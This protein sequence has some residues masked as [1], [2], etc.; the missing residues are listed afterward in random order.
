VVPSAV[1]KHIADINGNQFA[2]DDDSVEATERYLAIC[3]L[4]SV[5]HIYSSYLEHLRNSFWDGQEIYPTTL[6]QAYNVLQRRSMPVPQS[7]LS[8][9][10]V[11]AFAQDSSGTSNNDHII[12]FQCGQQGVEGLP[13]QTLRLSYS[14]KYSCLVDYLVKVRLGS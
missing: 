5:N 14:V 6:H 8:G 4:Q 11:V 10:D 2:T 9:C 1:V 13:C 7:P 3:F 12:C